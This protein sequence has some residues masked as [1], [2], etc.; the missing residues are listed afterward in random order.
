[1]HQHE[2]ITNLLLGQMGENPSG[3]VIGGCSELLTA[4]RVPTSRTTSGL[5]L[6]SNLWPCRRGPAEPRAPVSGR[7][8]D[9]P[10][11]S[12]LLI[13]KPGGGA[14]SYLNENFCTMVIAPG[15]SNF[16]YL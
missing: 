13:S 7:Q 15:W 9:V 16:Q 10:A 6:A 2:Q 4:L 12:G 3:D 14:M 11:Q 5:S 8:P 1:V